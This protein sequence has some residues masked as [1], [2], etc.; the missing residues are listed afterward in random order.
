[1]SDPP[2]PERALP[3]PSLKSRVSSR[4]DP[5]LGARPSSSQSQVS[6]LKS[7]RSAPRSTPFQLPVS[8]PQSQVRR[9]QRWQH[10]GGG[11]QRW[12]HTSSSSA[13]MAASWGRA[14]VMASSTSGAGGSHGLL[15]SCV[16]QWS[17]ASS[18]S[19]FFFFSDANT[20]AAISA[21]V[22]LG[23]KY[24]RIVGKQR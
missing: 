10:R 18:F 4:P 6:N 13:V 1:M 14:S 11:G 3:A 15:Y 7:P 2:A 17:A 23:C 12:R 5:P 8:S 21:I 16:Y 24:C 19:L 9:A 22:A 20:A